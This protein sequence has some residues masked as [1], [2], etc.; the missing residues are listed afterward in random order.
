MTNSYETDFVQWL[1]E[2][3]NLLLKWREIHKVIFENRRTPQMNQ[4]YDIF[5]S[6]KLS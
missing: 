3:A 6:R 5:A 1:D 4:S 2:Q